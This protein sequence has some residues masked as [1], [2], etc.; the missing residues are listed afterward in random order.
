MDSCTLNR[1]YQPLGWTMATTTPVASA[2]S[3]AE[4]PRRARCGHTRP[5]HS[6][7]STTIN[8]I[9]FGLTVCC[10]WKWRHHQEWQQRQ[11]RPRKPHWHHHNTQEGSNSDGDTVVPGSR[12]GTASRSKTAKGRLNWLVRDQLSWLANMW[13]VAMAESCDYDNA[14][15]R[16]PAPGRR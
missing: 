16:G 2:P 5:H 15:A 10:C 9:P 6:P 1:S 4:H 14:T 11:R 7:S 3:T 13:K 8:T 12:N